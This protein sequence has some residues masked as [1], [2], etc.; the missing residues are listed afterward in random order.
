MPTDVIHPNSATG[1]GG[2]AFSGS[3][4]GGEEGGRRELT[5][6]D[7][8]GTQLVKE[9]LTPFVGNREDLDARAGLEQ[10]RN[11]ARSAAVLLLQD[12]DVRIRLADAVRGEHLRL[13]LPRRDVRLC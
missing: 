6:R 3:A 10:R 2:T 4:D 7:F 11:R 1:S 12:H 13:H 9:G 8:V 5:E